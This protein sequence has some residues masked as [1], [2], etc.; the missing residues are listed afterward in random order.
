MRAI[1]FRGSNNTSAEQTPD[2]GAAGYISPPSERA[3]QGNVT[4]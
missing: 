2:L 1:A 3:A 4:G